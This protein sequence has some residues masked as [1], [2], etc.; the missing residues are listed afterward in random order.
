MNEVFQEK[1]AANNDL[2]SKRRHEIH[3]GRLVGLLGG[4]CLRDWRP[5]FLGRGKEGAKLGR[6]QELRQD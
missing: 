5:R 6:D 4:N 3:Q 2:E 1:E